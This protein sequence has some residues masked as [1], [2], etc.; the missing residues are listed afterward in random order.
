M[1][2]SGETDVGYSGSAI[3][4]GRNALNRETEGPTVPVK[5]AQA[6]N[7]RKEKE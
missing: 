1:Q 3:H 6:Q 4:S 5:F 2:S 7:K